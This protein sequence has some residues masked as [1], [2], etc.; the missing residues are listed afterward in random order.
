MTRV[1]TFFQECPIYVIKISI[2]D[3]TSKYTN[4]SRWFNNISALPEIQ[5]AV[6]DITKGNVQR[7]VKVITTYTET[8][9]S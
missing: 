3:Y 1:Y 7:E 9:S 6:Q 4:L 8:I 5:E 2:P